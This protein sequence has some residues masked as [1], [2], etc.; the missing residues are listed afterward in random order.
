MAAVLIRRG[1]PLAP[2]QAH[3]EKTTTTG[4]GEGPVG[5]PL[6]QPAA[7]TRPTS[8]FLMP[9]FRITGRKWLTYAKEKKKVGE[10]V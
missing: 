6:P 8:T 5:N 9:V 2:R 7:G 3:R 4:Q 10:G 1:R